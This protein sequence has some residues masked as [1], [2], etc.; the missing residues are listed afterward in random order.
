M[1]FFF[2]EMKLRDASIL[3][4]RMWVIDGAAHNEARVFGSPCGRAALF[5]ASGC[6]GG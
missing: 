6:P 4:H 2:A 3:R 5:D 1:Q